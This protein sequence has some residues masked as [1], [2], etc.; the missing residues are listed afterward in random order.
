[1][2]ELPALRSRDVK[3]FDLGGRR[4]QAIFAPFS[5]Y[6]DDAGEWQDV[7][8][9][10]RFDGLDRLIDKHLINFRADASGLAIWHKP[11]GRGI[12]FEFPRRPDRV[13]NRTAEWDLADG[14]TW[15]LTAR[16]TGLKTE[17]TIVAKRGP[18]T[19]TFA[20]QMLGGL[21]PPN[22]DGNGNLVQPAGHFVIQR[23]EVYGANGV[24]YQTSGWSRQGGNISFSFDDTSLPNEALPYVI[25]PTTTFNVAAG[26]D[27][28]YVYRAS[29]SVYPPDTSTTVDTS[30]TIVGVE[31]NLS[32]GQFAILI[33]LLRWDTAS[34]PDDA[35]IDA[36]TLRLRKTASSPVSVDS[37]SLVA[38]WYEP[39]T[40]DTE[41]YT[42]TVVSDAHSGTALTSITADADNDFALTNLSS[43]N[44]TG[45][46]GL[47]LHI[48]GGQPTGN[49]TA[50]FASFDH[51]TLT[52]PRLIVEYT[53]GGTTHEA[54]ASL[55]SVA[56]LTPA[57]TASYA[58]SAALSGGA[59]LS[60]LASVTTPGPGMVVGSPLTFVG[61]G[62]IGG[63]DFSSGGV[64]HQAEA[65]LSGAASL[66][67]AARMTYAAAS[68]LDGAAVLAATGRLTLPGAA[69]LAAGAELTASGTVPLLGDA[70]L[71][72][73]ATLSPAARATYAA[74]SAL[75]GSASL[76][77]DAR[78]TFAAEATLPGTAT[79]TAPARVTY[80]ASAALPGSATMAAD[81]TAVRTVTAALSGS[82]VLDAAA[83]ATYAAQ[84]GLSGSATLAAQ[85]L[86]TLGG[87]A[88][89]AGTATLTA[90]AVIAGGEI[91]EAEAA[92]SATASVAAAARLQLAAASAL[93]V[94]ATVS[95]TG[96]LTLPGASA[97]TGAAT[98]T[99]P[100]RM[101]LAADALLPGSAALTPGARL[102]YAASAALVASGN[103]SPAARL[104]LSGG[105]ALSSVSLILA[106]P[107]AIRTVEASLAGSASFT[108]SAVAVYAAAIQLI[109][110][111]DLSA[112]PRMTLAALLALSAIATLTAD[113]Q[114]NS[115]TVTI[116]VRLLGF[117]NPLLFSRGMD[118]SLLDAIGID[119]ATIN[120]R[121]QD[122]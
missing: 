51:S 107:T 77:A 88:L 80:A 109:A 45:Y 42:A 65:A 57:A 74:A 60:A 1:M 21:A 86:L 53:E 115:S 81:A 91:H 97:L 38:E 82:A 43:V 90:D 112:N 116:L 6:Q 73:A 93:N 119:Q 35:T 92:L 96:R 104:S 121:G 33:S 24:T 85:P 26:G 29:S 47:R 31:K 58:A 69:T 48:S 7:D 100:A 87:S 101:T 17:A 13:V 70:A 61:L 113:A 67:P 49:N 66:A 114:V 84:A 110:T 34:I 55:S 71:S 23:P 95:A 102:T 37:R 64:T 44:K 98:L 14:T 83:R 89:L 94:A 59:T 108:A 3:V 46:T 36:A 75:A 40:I 28:G 8:L 12:K 19:Y 27:D 11:T 50:Y 10:F 106:A 5:H 78:M 63:V 39:G 18:K 72:A 118:R 122:A 117:D 9:N 41:D 54:A 111:G 32:G 56:S 120:R 4:R 99:A 30:D 62:A 22:A 52:E 20:G 15:R 2:A 105:A 25:D 68:A 103:V 76:S 79:L 16:K